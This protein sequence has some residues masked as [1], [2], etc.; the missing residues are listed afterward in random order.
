MG[1]QCSNTDKK[2]KLFLF[3]GKT[4]PRVIYLASCQFKRQYTQGAVFLLP[5]IP[6]IKISWISLLY[7]LLCTKAA[8]IL[9]LF[10][11]SLTSILS[12]FLL[13][14]LKLGQ[15]SYLRAFWSAS[16]FYPFLPPF[17]KHFLKITLGAPGWHSGLS[18]GLLN[19]MQVII[20]GSW[21]RAP[22]CRACLRFSLSLCATPSLSKKTKLN[23]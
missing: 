14:P 6:Q 13:I 5:N 20:S 8:F 12:N 21:V 2:K 7:M 15:N 17:N 11:F 22:T 1:I 19:S 23:L 3:P 16:L 18:A 9:I 10:S 4:H